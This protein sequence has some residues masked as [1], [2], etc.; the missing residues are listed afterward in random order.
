VVTP[1]RGRGNLAACSTDQLA[2]IVRT[3]LKS[4][5]YHPALLDAFIAETDLALQPRPP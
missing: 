2:A 5:Q 1:Q 3:R 4:L